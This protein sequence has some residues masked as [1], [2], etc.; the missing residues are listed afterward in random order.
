MVLFGTGIFTLM[1]GLG[2]ATMAG[3]ARMIRGNIL[4]AK[5]L[6]YIEAARSVGYSDFIILIRHIMPNV[7]APTIVQAG[8]NFGLA[9]IAEATFSFIGLGIQ[10]PTASWGSMLFEGESY[11]VTAPWVDLFPGLAILVTVVLLNLFADR[12][13]DALD[14]RLRQA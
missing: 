1:V 11:Y 7:V 6:Q 14:P 3:Y 5:Q 8:Y 10:P 13:R 4:K 2:I 12:I 9:I